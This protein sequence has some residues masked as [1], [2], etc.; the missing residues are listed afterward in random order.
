MKRMKRIREGEKRNKG[1]VQ[2]IT[3]VVLL[4]KTSVYHYAF[5]ENSTKLYIEMDWDARMFMAV[6]KI[7][8]GTST[9]IAKAYS[10]LLCWSVVQL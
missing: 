6:L 2:K 4:S 9:G 3:T 8:S 7:G 1:G 5:W 10:Y